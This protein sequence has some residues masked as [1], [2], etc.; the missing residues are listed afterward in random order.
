MAK[1]YNPSVNAGNDKNDYDDYDD[2]VVTVFVVV[3]V[4]DGYYYFDCKLI[5]LPD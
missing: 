3:V 4:G 2:V 5:F 1:D